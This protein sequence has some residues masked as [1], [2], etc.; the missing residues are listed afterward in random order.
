MAQ[1]FF[2]YGVMGS[3]KTAEL[4]I[5]AH[6]YE[7]IGKKVLIFK[8]D[9]DT[10]DGKDVIKSRI[11]ASV[12]CHLM[13]EFDSFLNVGLL[14]NVECVLID[15]AQFLTEKQVDSLYKM[16]HGFHIPV[17]CYGLKT[18]FS[19]KLFEGSK[20]LL[21]IADKISEIKNIC[22]CGRKAIFSARANE[23]GE[24]VKT[25]EQI[26][27]GYDYIPVCSFHYY[28]GVVPD[29]DKIKK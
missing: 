24:I 27:I 12:K 20:R 29:Y 1:L 9:C 6:R 28:L 15:E 4:I 13:S 26:Q 11:G 10:R 21:E 22:P 19:G 3:A 8:P 7:E 18:D 5:T 16:V 17:I 2:K 25:G 14:K 23:D